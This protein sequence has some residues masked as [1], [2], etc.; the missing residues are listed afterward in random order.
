MKI[1]DRV[2]A[3][4]IN[5][6]DLALKMA[7]EGSPIIYCDI[8]CILKDKDTGVVYILDECGNWDYVDTER[9]EVTE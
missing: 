4:E 6:Y 8:E 1:F 5:L 3:E 2:N 9:Y 7:K